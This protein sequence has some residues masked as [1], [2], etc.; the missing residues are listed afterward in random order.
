M[1]PLPTRPRRGAALLLAMVI[2]TLVATLAAGMVWQQSRAVSIEA[3]ERARTQAGWILA[4]ALDWARMVLREDARSPG[5]TPVWDTQLAETSLSSFLS[6]DQQNNADIA[7]QAFLSGGIE[8]AQAR[9]NLLNLFDNTG[10]VVQAQVELLQRL[11]ELAGVPGDT[12]GRLAEGLRRAGVGTPG[13][14]RDGS[15]PPLTPHK[16]SQL[17]WLGLDP[18]VVERLAP[19]VVLLPRRTPVNANTAPREVLVAALGVDPGTAERIIQQR[20]RKVFKSTEELQAGLPQGLNFPGSVAVTT[21]FFVVRG[22]L[23]LDER[24]L[25]EQSLVERRSG[26]VIVLSRERRSLQ[27]GG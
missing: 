16:A 5:A 8:D 13:A 17:V 6:A 9:Y 10:N 25:E 3:A 12:A 7:L 26:Q 24:V 1:R 18:A 19:F 2:L 22:R 23:R 14:G 15:A 27:I 11:C 21:S 20:Q 4:G